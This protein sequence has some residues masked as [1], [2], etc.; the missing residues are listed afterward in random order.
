MSSVLRQANVNR[1]TNTVTL[2]GAT[3]IPV[4]APEITADSV[5]LTGLKTVAGTPSSIYVTTVTPGTG[6]NILGSAGN[7]C[8][9]NYV[10]L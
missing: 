5:I 2:N 6:F 9:Y 1:L 10:V 8:T 7:L 3:E 4:V